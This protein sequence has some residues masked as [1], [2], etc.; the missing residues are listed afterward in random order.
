MVHIKI[1][2]VCPY[3]KNC[4]QLNWK[5][6]HVVTMLLQVLLSDPCLLICL[7]ISNDRSAA[8][9]TPDLDVV[10]WRCSIHSTG[11]PLRLPPKPCTMRSKAWRCL[12][13]TFER[14]PGVYVEVRTFI[15]R[16]FFVESS[17]SQQKLLAGLTAVWW[18]VHWAAHSGEPWAVAYASTWV[19]QDP[20]LS[21]PIFL[22]VSLCCCIRSLFYRSFSLYV[23]VRRRIECRCGLASFN[24]R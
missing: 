21:L 19:G 17:S 4:T 15:C 10:S 24:N 1:M 23:R 5:P 12:R 7:R 13:H 22:P 14:I 3:D 18:V 9:W 11:T 6:S 20:N 16:V 8:R 2:I